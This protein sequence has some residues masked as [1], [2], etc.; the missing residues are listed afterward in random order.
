MIIYMYLLK[1]VL[2]LCPHL[3]AYR[4]RASIEREAENPGITRING[5]ADNES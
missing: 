5:G 4:V 1:R 2:F 3:R